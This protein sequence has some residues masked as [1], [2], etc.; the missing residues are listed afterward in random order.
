MYQI[1]RCDEIVIALDSYCTVLEREHI[2]INT[3]NVTGICLHADEFDKYL[4]KK[5]KKVDKEDSDGSDDLE[6]TDGIMVLAAAGKKGGKKKGKPA[7]SAFQMLDVEE[8]DMSE[9]PETLLS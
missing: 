5:A 1:I 8:P 2:A 6:D 9:V 7:M 3:S 4:Q